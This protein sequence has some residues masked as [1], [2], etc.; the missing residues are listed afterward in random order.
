MEKDKKISRRTF[1]SAAGGTIISIGLPGTF[2]R[3]AEA[4]Q[5]ALATSIRPDGKPRLPPGQ[6]AVKKIQDMGGTPGAT[7]I[8]NWNQG[9]Q[10]SAKN[11]APTDTRCYQYKRPNII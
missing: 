7:T 8:A 11:K 5:H 2:I 3:L 1:L 4:E 10:W 9:I 6:A